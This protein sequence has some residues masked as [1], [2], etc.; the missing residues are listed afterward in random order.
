MEIKLL[1]AQRAVTAA[2]TPERIKEAPEWQES[3]VIAV[4]IRANTGNA[5]FIYVSSSILA[6]AAFG[7]VLT[8]GETLT[9]DVSKFFDAYLDLSKI[10]IDASVNGDGISYVAFEVLH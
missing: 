2:G 1:T 10:L 9:L 4:T 7:Y 8:A 3:K 5:G 6:S